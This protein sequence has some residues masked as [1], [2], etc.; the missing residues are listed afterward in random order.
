MNTNRHQTKPRHTR[1]QGAQRGAAQ[2]EPR[3][4]DQRARSA[5]LGNESIKEHQQVTASELRKRLWQLQR[6]MWKVTEFNRLRGC[7]RWLAAGAGV[8]SLKWVHH[9]QAYWGNLQ[10]SSSVWSSP[11]SA[12]AISKT[13][14]EEVSTALKTWFDQDKAHS[15]E[16]VTLT[17][18]HDRSQT[19]REVW[20]T[21]A[22]AW[23][24]ITGTA[25]WRGGARYEGDKKRFGI[26]HWLKSVEVTHGKNGWHVHVHALLFINRELSGTEREVMEARFYDRWR[27]AAERKGFKAPSREHGVKMENAVREKN[28]REL[29]AY[30]AKGALHSVSETLSWEITAGQTAK[31]ARSE[32]NRS[33]FQILDSIRLSGDF[34]AK[35]PDVQI[36][37]EWESGSL[38]RR[39]MAWSKGAKDALGVT[40]VDDEE[41]EANGEGLE[42]GHEVAQI[43]FEEWSRTQENGEKLRDDL[44]KR[45]E[46]VEFIAGAKSKKGARLRA[47]KI[48]SSYQI[49]YRAPA[50]KGFNGDG[51]IPAPESPP[52]MPAVPSL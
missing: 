6:V 15:V 37:R 9:G 18:A 25:S 1:P 44:V 30:M 45:N 21:V 11:L 50:G 38:G 16:F 32:E 51:A 29:G 27:K 3:T 41:A 5:R 19:L 8:V 48:L 12:A 34:S 2:A 4:R 31:T 33:P 36:W 39:Q 49:S 17:L 20:D 24:G 35:N 14:A 23:R 22:Y 10:T 43:G 26:D 47:Q 7:H 42:D 28:P 13:R 52:D 40:V 46:I